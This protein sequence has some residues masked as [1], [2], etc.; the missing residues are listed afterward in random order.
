MPEEAKD[1]NNNGWMQAAMSGLM[2]GISAL[3][4]GGPK[5][6]YKY[7][8][9][10]ANFQNELN[11]KNA[12]WVLAQNRILSEEQRKYDSP[13][14]QM[15]RFRQAGLNPHLAYSQGNVGNMNSPVTMGSIPSVQG[16]HI[17]TS[18]PDIAGDFQKYQLMQSQA[19]LTNAKIEESTIKQD[20]LKAQKDVLQAN[21]YLKPAYVNAIVDGLEATAKMKQQ[22]ATFLTSEYKYEA[23][24]TQGEKKMLLELE[25]LA[26]KVGLNQ[27]DLSIKAK[28]LESKEFQNA[29]QE[30]QLK[31]LKDG[32]VT[33]QHI[34]Q[35]IM[36]LLQ[37]MM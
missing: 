30:I 8:K 28:I 2:S 9:K 25:Q 18:Y 3:G 14:Q 19:G 36:L 13:E 34:Y 27:A 10:T 1:G 5:R 32:E 4:K 37:K 35:G 6:G 31:W 22:E 12:E 24:S 17:D 33:P 26:Q 11:R 20:V 23:I 21:P 16:G 29:L 15:E 7:Y